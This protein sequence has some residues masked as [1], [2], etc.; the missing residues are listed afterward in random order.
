MT[1]RSRKGV[2]AFA[3]MLA[4][5]LLE[6][7]GIDVSKTGAGTEAEASVSL[8]PSETPFLQPH[9]RRIRNRNPVWKLNRSFRLT[10]R[11]QRP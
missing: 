5:F 11:F 1:I 10:R 7:C 8:L 9:T 4:L 3:L 2:L 6:A